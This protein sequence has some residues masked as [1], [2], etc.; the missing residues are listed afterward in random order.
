MTQGAG[1]HGN[2]QSGPTPRR[3]L[4]IGYG[5]TLR[6][7]DGAGVRAAEAVQALDLPGV[8]VLTVHQ[9]NPE[10]AADL[11]AADVAVFL[12]ARAFDGSVRV[13][14]NEI[15]PKARSCSLVHAGDPAYLLYLSRLAYGA[16]PR[17]WMVTLPAVNFDLGEGLSVTAGR[18]VE[19]ALREVQRICA[20]TAVAARRP[21][22][23]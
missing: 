10:L 2:A 5:N 1:L 16:A 8:T 7:D 15:A 22:P 11:A 13:D 12:D 21:G 14:V 3:I 4:V 18:A 19:D 20:G 23:A 9:L 17:A 6:G